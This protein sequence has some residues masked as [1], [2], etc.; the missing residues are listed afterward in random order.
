MRFTDVVVREVA[1]TYAVAMAY[2]GVVGPTYQSVPW[3]RKNKYTQSTQIL[4]EIRPG[5][6]RFSGSWFRRRLQACASSWCTQALRCPGGAET[7]AAVR[8]GAVVCAS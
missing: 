2:T 3:A 8:A 5:P 6:R 7:S 4:T 1:M